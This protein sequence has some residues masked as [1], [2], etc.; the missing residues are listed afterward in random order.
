MKEPGVR[1]VNCNGHV[2]G[3]PVSNDSTNRAL[4]HKIKDLDA[5]ILPR[6]IKVRYH[7]DPR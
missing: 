3:E 1:S 5:G 6:Q 7:R 4:T 2:L